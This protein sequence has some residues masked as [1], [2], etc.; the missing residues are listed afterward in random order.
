MQG[1][2]TMR[3]E[4]VRRGK[5]AMV[6]RLRVFIS[7][8]GDV[9]AA[10]ELAAQTVE[11]V[12]QDYARCFEIEP[13]MW[14][15]EVMLASGHFQDAIEPPSAFDIVVLILWSRLGTPLPE[16]TAVREYRG[17]D[18]R[19]PVTG[20]EWEYEEA[21]A[22]SRVRGAP[23]L[24]V[25][26]SRERV[27]I[28]GWDVTRREG[29]LEQLSAL[30][31]FWSRHFADRG[32]FL[33]AYNEYSTLEA[34]TADFESHL[35]QL[36]DRRAAK[37]KPSASTNR[38]WKKAP[39]RG[40][41]A[42]E[43]EHA[44]IF[45]GRDEAVGAAILQLC[46]NAE[47]GRAFLLV[48]G[49][50]GAGK[51]SL[52]K[53][54]VA[55]RLFLPRRITGSAFLRRVIFRPSEI[56]AG[57]DIFDSL[58]RALTT[59][60]G[61]DTGLPELVGPSMSVAQ[62]ATHLREAVNYPGLPVATA[63]ER[64]AE[65]A[66]RKGR[67][68][69]YKQPKLLLIVDQ[70]EE[71]FTSEDVTPDARARFVA[72]LAGLVRSGDVWV[73]ATMRSDFWHRTSDTPELVKLAEGTGRLDLLSPRPSEISQMIRRPAEAADIQFE[74]DLAGGI[75]LNDRI[76]EE[77]AREPG[78]LP[79]LSYL[80]DQLYRRDV[81]EK[82]G[83]TL[84]YAS[85]DALGQLKGAI[86]TRAEGIL[87]AQPEEVRAALRPLLF[88]L[89]Q[90]SAN[91]GYSEQITARS[92]PI[93]AFADGSAKRRLL[94]LFLDPAARLVI[95]DS[96]H[97][98]TA[99]VRVAH[100]ALLTEWQR[101]QECL[102]GYAVDLKIRHMAEERLARF[103]ELQLERKATN[104][105]GTLLQ[106]IGLRGEAGLLR[107]LDLDDA[108]RLMQAYNDDIA[109]DLA[110]FI[111]RSARA[112]GRERAFTIRALSAVVILMVVLS[113]GATIETISAKQN[114]DLAHAALRTSHAVFLK[115]E[116]AGDA[117]V[118]RNSNTDDIAL[119][120]YG[121]ECDLSNVLIMFDPSKLDWQHDAASCNAR[122]GW[123]LTREGKAKEAMP[124]LIKALAISKDLVRAE[125][126]NR[127]WRD[128]LAAA[129][130]LLDKA[131]NTRS[132]GK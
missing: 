49:A 77:A 123:V 30:D 92:S 17:V 99:R 71:L 120:I 118:L 90:I 73:I 21:L 126:M 122:I 25:Y 87:A 125:P 63:L 37:A 116:R 4:S 8:P 86:A 62:L 60:H 132:T 46:A 102:A 14:E 59:A 24:L 70:L 85:Y 54:G 101:A 105:L 64:L 65:G 58:A 18:G 16:K 36:L 67:M 108:K 112:A 75:P 113:T 96:K 107:D 129:Q 35:R 26:R 97:G 1:I 10:R 12:A 127:N 45:F 124:Y 91:E 2:L 5:R 72:L 42:Y 81:V 114:S 84:T 74:S 103:Q 89:V 34:F 117:L 47:A 29:E 31:K 111:Q 66:R 78:A 79:L 69:T 20:T 28:D 104:H 50:S 130:K 55:P 52:V 38:A 128:D 27:V 88:S 68:L 7:S 9:G 93:N 15:H 100:E 53:A 61:P 3:T 119:S 6:E 41:E 11:K 109:P 76:A 33:A 48:L 83:S 40:L 39:F 13:Y 51:S 43:F 22:A 115:V 80:L 106:R 57:E 19:V 95:A 82:G 94:D 131:R 110:N 56:L 44:P 32:A 98:A 23:D 121:S